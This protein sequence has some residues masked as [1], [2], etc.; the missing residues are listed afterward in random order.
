M[1]NLTDTIARLSAMRAFQPGALASDAAQDRL[2]DFDGFGDNPGALRARCYV[3]AGLASGAPLVVVLHGC[4]QT[5]AGYDHGAGW[6]RLADRHGFALLFPEQQR[7][8]NP[9]LCFNWFV[10][11]DS[12]RDQGEP[13][14]IRNMA[15]HMIAEHRLDPARVFVTGLSAGGA[16]TGVML[17]T[18]PDLFTGG[19]VIAGLPFGSAT[20]VPEAFDRMRGHGVPARAELARRARAAAGHQG[21]WPTLSVWQGTADHTVA[22]SNADAISGQWRDLHG[23]PDR[24]T[25]TDIVDGHTHRLWQDGAGRAV[26]EEYRIAGMGHGTPID[27]GAGAD[28]GA[29]GAYMLDAGIASSHLILRFW[30]LETDAAEIVAD[31]ST[32]GS[33]AAATPEAIGMP[34]IGRILPGEMPA[35]PMPGGAVGSVI[36]KAMR[37]AGLMK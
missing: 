14:S 15:V 28:H 25:R 36:E 12:M 33:A 20:S 34:H 2:T 7:A 13:L 23:L 18:Y 21:D 17:V 11:E 3:P 6:S 22:Q 9:N 37:S 26:L 27:P 16:M 5:A 29:S 19:A 32:A 10:P 1:R 4:T 30:G 31:S 24:P 35:F 8:N